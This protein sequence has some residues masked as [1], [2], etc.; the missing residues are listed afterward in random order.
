MLMGLD[1]F[2]RAVDIQNRRRRPGQSISN[3]IQTNGIG[4]DDEWARFFAEHGFLVGISIDG[5]RELH[6]LHRF[7]RARTSVFDRVMKAVDHMNA[8][9]VEYN[10]L[11]VINNDTVRYPVE[12][13]NYLIGSGFH[14]LQFIPC[15]EVVDGETAPFSV[16]TEAYGDFL[17]RLFDEW[18]ENGYPYVSIRLFDNLLQYMVGQVPE[19]CMFKDSC[20]WD[21]VVEHNGDIYPCDFFVTPEWR[22][23]NIN[24]DS[25]E[26]ILE[27][28][29]YL[30]FAHMRDRRCEMC[31][32][33]EWLGF[34]HRGCVKFR[35]LPGLDYDDANYLC[36]PYKKF[37]DYARDRYRFLTWDIVRRH[38]GRPVPSDI[39]RNDLC[40]C[41]S[42]KKFKKCCEKYRHIAQK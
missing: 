20:G 34:C 39:G 26:D 7:T 19:S 16:N 17:C 11:A 23:G 10:I 40:F 13:Y 2:R 29:K 9:G 24:D 22:L 8:N 1:F 32:D 6:D 3:V 4:I 37:F 21:L 18:F 42:G 33:C 15:L 27:Q 41:G 28:P 31:D 38:T 25:L 30:E 12:I 14:Y 5:P 36:E 35:Y